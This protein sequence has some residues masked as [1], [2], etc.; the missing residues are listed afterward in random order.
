M[1]SFVRSLHLA[2]DVLYLF[3]RA[4]VCAFVCLPV[5]ETDTSSLS[6]SSSSIARSPMCA[7]GSR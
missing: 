3:M 4:F 2:L 7:R 1:I 6:S 5:S